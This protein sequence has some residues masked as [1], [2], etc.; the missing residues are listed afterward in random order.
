MKRIIGIGIALVVV[1]VGGL[2]LLFLRAPHTMP[3]RTIDYKNTTYV[4]DGRY[5]ALTSGV[6]DIQA[7]PGSASHIITRYFGNEARGDLNSDGKEDVAFLLTQEGGGSGTFF[8]VVAALAN[9]SGYTGS[10]A[11]FIGDR[12]APQTTE[13]ERNGIMLINYADRAPGEPLSA[14]P[15]IGKTLRL[16]FNAAENQF[17]KVGE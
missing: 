12:I 8:Y 17:E 16:H 4:I 1:V 15:S 14:Q 11:Y 7:A 6:S 2:Y 13:A 3:V 5:V 9:D 10:Q